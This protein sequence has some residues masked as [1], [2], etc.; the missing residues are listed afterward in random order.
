MRRIL[1]T[2]ESS[3]E[4]RVGHH[5]YLCEHPVA[6]SYLANGLRAETRTESHDFIVLAQTSDLRKL[7]GCEWHEARMHEG[8][9]SEMRDWV[10]SRVRLLS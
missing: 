9:W 5:Q 6:V 1:H 3:H 10:L 4:A 7:R 8:I 2:F